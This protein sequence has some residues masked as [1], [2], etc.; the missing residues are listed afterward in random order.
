M[1]MTEVLRSVTVTR[2]NLVLSRKGAYNLQ[3]N[4]SGT[5]DKV[6]EGVKE[7]VCYIRQSFLF[8]MHQPIYLPK[9][10]LNIPNIN[11]SNKM[12]SWRSLLSL[13]SSLI[14]ILFTCTQCLTLCLVYHAKTNFSTAWAHCSLAR[15]V[16]TFM[17]RASVR[18]KYKVL[19]NLFTLWH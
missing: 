11:Y 19:T 16:P 9:T 17:E 8:P 1:R 7:K 18:E 3:R 13:K 4:T 10:N 12:K 15:I 14:K 2:D 6:G 5:K